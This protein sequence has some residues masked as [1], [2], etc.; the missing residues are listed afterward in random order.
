MNMLLV[1]SALSALVQGVHPED[2]PVAVGQGGNAPQPFLIVA[3]PD[4]QYYSETAAWTYHFHAQ[5]Q[6]TKD[7]A[8]AFNIAFATHLGDIVDNGAAN[9]AEWERA[10][11]AIDILDTVLPNGLFPYGVCLGNHD[12]EIVSDKNS[13]SAT[14]D[15]FFGPDRYAGRP[16]YAGHSTDR[17]NH[18][19]LFTVGERRF[20]H[21]TLEWRPDLSTFS[22]AQSMIN[23]FPGVPTICSTHE[24][25]RDA[26]T[27][28]TGAGR[29]SAGQ[30]TWINL[31]RA[32][33]QIFLFLN[34]HFASGVPN[35]NGEHAIVG[36]NDAAREVFEML[37]DYQSW[38]EGGSGY[39]RLLRLDER[40]SVL[41]VRSFSPSLR[42]YLTDWNSQ[43]RY[44]ID[45]PNRFDN[46]PS[47]FQSFSFRNGTQSYAGTADVELSGSNPGTAAGDATVLT[48]AG[49]DG[50]PA[51][52]AQALVRFDNCFGTGP[53]Q[54]PPGVDVVLAKLRVTVVN[55]GS[56]FSLHDMMIPWTEQST[57]NS[58][59]G[60]I[61]ADG[62]EAVA[63]PVTV[64]GAQHAGDLLPIQAI[65]LDVTSS[66]RAWL[67]GAPNHGWALLPFAT[68]NN[69]DLLSS[70]DGGFIGRPQLTITTTSTPVQTA[71]FQ[72]GVNIYLGTS[73]ADLRQSAPTTVT[74]NAATMFIDA[75][76]PNGSNLVRQGLLK[77]DGIFGDA[78]NQVPV[79][80]RVTSALL[81]LTVTQE[82]SGFTLHR[83][84][85]PWNE[86]STWTSLV[87]GVS[88][89]DAEAHLWT[90]HVAGTDADVAAVRPGV[91]TIDVTDSVQAWERGDAN[92]GW[93]IAPRV[94]GANGLEIAS[95]ES[96]TVAARPRLIVKYLAEPRC[97]ADINAD[98]SVDGDDVIIFFQSWDASQPAGDFNDD[99][100]VDGDDVIAFFVSWD[101]G[102]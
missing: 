29:S 22:W 77:F 64:V 7:S 70:E 15:R 24:H 83:M 1:C 25:V 94:F 34:G 89:D 18:A 28:G 4:T 79:G 68:S 32:N 101:A 95:S 47:Q 78:A 12:F 72:H 91:V 86:S 59:A 96:P 75:S 53:A 90:E 93:L 16:W 49:S 23:A 92:H 51:A 44:V 69:V 84:L 82:G 87:A 19:Q 10:D 48:V 71:T 26:N 63:S 9:I 20:L 88:V 6:W 98:G 36:I 56:G 102:C 39:M 65:D 5:T 99:D 73:D 74:G 80:A 97:D 67:A 13:G 35:H 100:S 21:L 61:S 33:P 40:N 31:I 62:I 60:G 2:H 27:S 43:F 76:D 38:T 11:A 17:Q 50:V 55:S 37:S 81:A 54:F 41:S 46:R 85:Q 52:P 8:S 30:T 66:V 3:Y 42:R 58:L 57:W 14:Y 45:F